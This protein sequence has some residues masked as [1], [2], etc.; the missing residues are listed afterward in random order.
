V[1]RHAVVRGE[2]ARRVVAIGTTHRPSTRRRHESLRVDRS[3]RLVAAEPAF[4]RE[5]TVHYPRSRGDSGTWARSL[6]NG[7]FV[8]PARAL[9]F[10]HVELA[11]MILERPEMLPDDERAHGWV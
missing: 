4:A 1:A 9:S 7:V 5:S 10:G 2:S 3:R 11:A 8:R 6:D